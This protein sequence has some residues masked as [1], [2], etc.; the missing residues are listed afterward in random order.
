MAT[1]CNNWLG[2][3]NGFHFLAYYFHHLSCKER[4]SERVPQYHELYNTLRTPSLWQ[5]AVYPKFECG[6]PELGLDEFK[7]PV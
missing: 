1:L 6:L 2:M 7:Q 3:V 4:L 5:H